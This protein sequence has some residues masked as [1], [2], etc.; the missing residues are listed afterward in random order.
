MDYKDYYKT[1]GVARG[2]DEAAIKQAYR[3]LARQYH[4]DRNKDADAAQRMS[5]I[6]EANTVLSDPQKRAAYDALGPDGLNGLGGQPGWGGRGG[7]Q[8]M[9]GEQFSDFFAS[10]F[11]Q[12]RSDPFGAAQARRPM[13]RAGQDVET[14]IE[15]DLA[16]AYQGASRRITLSGGREGPRTLEVT[17]PKGIR[18]GQKIRLAGYGQPGR[19]GGPAG[20]LLL[21]VG[22]TPDARYRVDGADVIQQVPVTPWEAALG[23]EIEV[24]TLAGELAVQVPA[25]SDSGRKLRLKGRGLPGKVPGDYFLELQVVLPAA[26]SPRARE[27]YETLARELAFNPRA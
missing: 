7:A 24:R 12:G 11:G 2:A 10:M 25:G 16:D 26:D 8:G 1:L 27:L 15:I 22:F 20:D 14:R 5:E 3:K 21:E 23:G 13:P 18:A 17:I 19:G 4:P 6:N 9:S